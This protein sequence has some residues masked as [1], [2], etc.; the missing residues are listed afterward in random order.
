MAEHVVVVGGGVA[1]IAASLRLAK[2]GVRVTLLER[3]NRLGGRAGSFRDAT[4]DESI[5]NCQHVALGC[6]DQYLDLLDEL[7]MGDAL[8]WT[9]EFHYIEP[10]GRRSSLP[11]P[12]LPSP[13]H[14]LPLLLKAGFLSLRERFA[15]ARALAG[16]KLGGGAGW[17]GRSFAAWLDHARQPER[18]V[19]RFWTPIVVS[20]CNARPADCDAA[21]AIKVFRDGFLKSAAAA[22]MGVPRVPLAELYAATPDLLAAVDGGVRLSAAVEAVEPNAVTLRDGERIDADAIVLATPC[23][24][25]ASLLDASPVDAASLVANLRRLR[26][27]TIVAV[28]AEFARP[29]T[30]LPHAVLLEAPF[31]WL[32]F[33][34]HGR[35][36]HAVASAAGPLAERVAD[37]L[38]AELTAELGSR[39]GV[40][41][42]PTWSR[43]V[44]ERRATFLVEP[45]VDAWRPK[46]DELGPAIWIAGDY[47]A[48]GWPATMEGAARSGR[49]A[50]ES[51]LKTLS[52]PV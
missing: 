18:A 37:D 2:R 23:T 28:H 45:G 17:S 43:V 19:E 15:I 38:I 26:H 46:G 44:K 27:S 20:A 25:A 52:A 7:G 35:R 29:V 36:V 11:I 9:S 32:F 10:D 14:G 5:D 30:D 41:A 40:D 51:V 21:A 12:D 39:F 4:I 33:K 6:C 8:E 13:F 42:E 48:T 16:V 34:D 1:G 31:D 50:A 24:A 3:S 22:R 49:A 47:T